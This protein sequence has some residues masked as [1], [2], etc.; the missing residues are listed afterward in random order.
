V[1][2]DLFSRRIPYIGHVS[3]ALMV[4]AFNGSLTQEKLLKNDVRWFD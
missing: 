4:A 2:P 1:L 3:S